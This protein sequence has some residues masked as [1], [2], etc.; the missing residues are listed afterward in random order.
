MPSIPGVSG[1]HAVRA[2]RKAGVRVVRQGKHMV[3]SNG[4]TILTIPRHSP[5]NAYSMGRLP[6]TPG[7]HLPSSGSCS[8]L[9]RRSLA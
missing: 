7:F 3:L 5:A 1:E 4:E 6:P 9:F 2:L 8:E